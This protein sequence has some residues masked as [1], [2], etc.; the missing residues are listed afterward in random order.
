LRDP[1]AGQARLSQAVE[2][3]RAARLSGFY[4][5]GHLTVDAAVGTAAFRS[6]LDALRPHGLDGFVVSSGDA[7]RHGSRGTEMEEQLCR[8]RALIES[9][10]WRRFS[11][12]LEESGAAQRREV[13]KVHASEVGA[14]E[15][16]A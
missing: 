2:A 5:C 1:Q 6:L 7:L 16:S 13:A 8:V 11:H 3:I 14:Y 10:G 15:E 4:V 12:L 9:P